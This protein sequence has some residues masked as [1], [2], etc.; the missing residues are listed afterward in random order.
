MLVKVVL[1]FLLA[2]VV[3]GWIGKALVRWRPVRRRA[4][5][6]ACGR[7]RLGRGP[8]ACGRA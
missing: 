3:I 2:L 5:C 4:A 6:P 8:C 7:P 1:L